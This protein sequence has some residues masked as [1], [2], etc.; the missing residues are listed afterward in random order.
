MYYALSFRPVLPTVHAF[1][2]ATPA[3]GRRPYL[4]GAF[5]LGDAMT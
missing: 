2:W 4:G 3:Q 1:T 5:F